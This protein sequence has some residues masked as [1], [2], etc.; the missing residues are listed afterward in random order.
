MHSKPRTIVQHRYYAEPDDG[1]KPEKKTNKHTN[2][3][4]KK[5]VQV[6]ALTDLPAHPLP[7]P[8]SE[9]PANMVSVRHVETRIPPERML[10]AHFSKSFAT[11]VIPRFYLSSFL[12][13]LISQVAVRLSH[14]TTEKRSTTLRYKSGRYCCCR[15]II[16]SYTSGSSSTSSFCFEGISHPWLTGRRTRGGADDPETIG[17]C[18]GNS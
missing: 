12:Y 8:A 6:Y 14:L 18:F 7:S 11:E 3:H 13:P 16:I 10:L 15:T 5:L 17:K 4:T 9:C 2:S 1:A